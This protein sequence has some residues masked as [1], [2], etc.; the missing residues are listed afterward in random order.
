[1][2]ANL[3]AV[4]AGH[5]CLDIIPG[6]TNT[7][8]KELNEII[9]PGKSIILSGVN[10]S[11]G[12]AVSNTGVA[13][14]ILG[15]KTKLMGKVGNDHFGK[16]VTDIL[17]EKGISDGV[18][19]SETAS[20]SFSIVISP[21]GIDRVFL[22]EPGVND[23]FDSGDIDYDAV[24]E[25][26][27]FHFGYPPSMKKMFIDD[28][29]EVVKVYK[30]VKSLNVIT[31]MDL[32]LP[33]PNSLS[34]KADWKY[35]LKRVLPYVDIFTPSLEELYYMLRNDEYRKLSVTSK[36]R[37]LIDALDMSVIHELGEELMGLGVK[38]AII[39]CGKKGLYIRT[40][41]YDVL[42]EVG[43]ILPIDPENWSERELLEGI[44][45][46]DRVVSANGSG[47][48][49]IAGF[50]ASVLTGK[51]I[52]EAMKTACAVGALCV[53][54]FDA[55]SGI[56]SM[57]ETDRLIEKG[58]DKADTSINDPYWTYNNIQNVWV[59]KMDSK[60]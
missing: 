56:K 25:A 48:T 18:T 8:N 55:L 51:S 11:T 3:D 36:G 28:G 54:T 22:H 50:L 44:Y 42:S 49:C 38:I 47:D 33:D 35:I 5:L 46:V 39:K 59:G 14:S 16:I 29:E 7:N 43:K 24:K 2:S 57:E 1:M 32:A 30:K 37:E 45:Q 12:G 9:S 6:F 52:E 23:L 19:V 40:Q 60:L 58:W 31:S 13:L 27:L 15:M 34:G 26:R 20:T 41:K 10:M 4:V 53:Q 21:P 17:K